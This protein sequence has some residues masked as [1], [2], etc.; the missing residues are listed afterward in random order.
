[1]F[2]SQWLLSKKGPLGTIWVAAHCHKRLKKQQ[3]K[4]TNISSS[5]EKIMRDE[6]PIVTYRILAY[7]LL[8]VV[9]VFSMKV[10]YLFHDCRNVLTKITEFSGSKKA[11][12]NME[13]MR[14]PF[15]SITLP[16][17][18]ELEAFNLEVLEDVSGANVRPHEEIL[19]E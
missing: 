16:E 13:A 18:F 5:V 12:A 19:L 10:E 8:G 9:R 17:S 11:K 15:H 6:V 3:V 14:A 7:L 1:M 4:E 2:Y